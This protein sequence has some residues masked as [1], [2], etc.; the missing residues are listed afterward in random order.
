MPVI[1][2][3]KDTVDADQGLLYYKAIGTAGDLP[4]VLME[5]G[6]GGSSGDWHYLAPLLA[7]HT[8]VFCYDRAGAGN[9]PRDDLGRGA[10]ANAQ[11][12]S[13]L[14]KKIPIRKPFV[15][16]GYSL[17][18]LYARYYAALHSRQVAGVVLLDATSTKYV[19]KPS[20]FQRAFRLLRIL[21]WSART[22]FT[23]LYW[24]LSGRK[25]ERERLDSFVKAASSPTF[26]SNVREELQAIPAVQAEVEQFAPKLT[27]PTLN[28]IAGLAPK[29]MSPEDAAQVRERHDQLMLDAPEPLSRNAVIAGANHGTLLNDQECLE[30]TAVH[31]LSFLQGVASP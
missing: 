27:H 14:V 6:G 29:T 4:D 5:H 26:A 20:E 19:F 31:I 1:A 18:G 21:H 22:R 10:A 3:E 9:S 8:R 16:V 12:L 11:R 17:G 28:V 13:R 7:A 2:Y 24:H 25:I 23:T 30:E 15:L